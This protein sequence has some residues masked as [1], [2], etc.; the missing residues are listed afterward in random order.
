MSIKLTTPF[1]VTVQGV[2]ESDTD[3]A[4]VSVVTDY[5]GRVQTTTFQVGTLVNNPTPNLNAG[6]QGILQNQTIIV[7]VHMD[8]G[9]WSDNH[10]HS[11]TIPPGSI[12]TNIQTSAV[13]QRNTGESF[14]AVPGGLMPG[15][16][17]AWTQV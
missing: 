7:T 2:T 15:V 13:G 12:L 5:I 10:G 11:G 9:A 8:T 1:N 16:I 14:M 4:L 3:G 17:T 6:P